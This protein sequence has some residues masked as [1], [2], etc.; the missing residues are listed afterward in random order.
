MQVWHILEFQLQ[1]NNSNRMITNSIKTLEPAILGLQAPTVANNN[2]RTV[3]PSL[4]SP[5][6]R[7]INMPTSITGTQKTDLQ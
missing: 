2:N 3:A 1:V 7:N 4:L 5:K 6:N